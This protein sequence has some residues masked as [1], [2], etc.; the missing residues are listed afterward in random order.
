MHLRTATLSS[1]D[2]TLRIHL[3]HLQ[4]RGETFASELEPVLLLF[5]SVALCSGQTKAG[6]LN[7][8]WPRAF[9]SLLVKHLESRCS[10]PR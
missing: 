1:E 4:I 3:I 2:G 5:Q 6:F 9:D 7:G 10:V 8:S